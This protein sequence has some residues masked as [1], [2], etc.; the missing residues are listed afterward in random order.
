MTASVWSTMPHIRA[1]PSRTVRVV[2]LNWETLGQSRNAVSVAPQA[3]RD[4]ADD[5]PAIDGQRQQVNNALGC[6]TRV[7]Y[8][9]FGHTM[10]N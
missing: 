1:G 5:A 10:L 9:R 4:L 3:A 7:T 6:V 8:V 2:H